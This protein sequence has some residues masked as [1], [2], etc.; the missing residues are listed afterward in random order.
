M[1]S[2]LKP[3]INWLLVFV[4]V[5]IV[6]RIWPQFGNETALF[7]CFCFAVI[8]LAGWMGRPTEELRDLVFLPAGESGRGLNPRST[9][10]A[11]DRIAGNKAC[12]R[13]QQQVGRL[14]I[15][16]AQLDRGWRR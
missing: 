4:S 13:W 15:R 1:R 5:A 6:L 9:F 11:P 2:F 7:I 12:T 3:S 14:Q 16:I 10:A 8:P